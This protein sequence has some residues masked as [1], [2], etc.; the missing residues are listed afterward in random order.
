MFLLSLH[1][2]FMIFRLQAAFGV[3]SIFLL[4]PVIVGVVLVISHCMHGVSR[5][6]FLSFTSRLLSE[7]SIPSS[8]D[9]VL[10]FLVWLVQH[11]LVCPWILSEAKTLHPVGD[12]QKLKDFLVSV[13]TTYT[14]CDIVQSFENQWLVHAWHVTE[15]VVSFLFCSI[16]SSSHPVYWYFLFGR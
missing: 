12:F 6:T 15:L 1:S 3:D 7:K 14:H 11:V 13:I 2:Y 8:V 5:F 16:V 4:L 9:R 10:G